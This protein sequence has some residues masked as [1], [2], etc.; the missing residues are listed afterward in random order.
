MYI[1]G[2]SWCSWMQELNCY[3]HGIVYLS[4]TASLPY[5]GSICMFISYDSKMTIAILA[6]WSLRFKSLCSIVGAKS[7]DLFLLLIA[8]IPGTSFML[9]RIKCS[10][11]VTFPP[12]LEE[13]IESTLSKYTANKRAGLAPQKKVVC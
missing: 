1:N 4:N 2:R 7:H 3:I 11:M 6:L 13:R 10:D 12:S 8:S 9:R 5:L